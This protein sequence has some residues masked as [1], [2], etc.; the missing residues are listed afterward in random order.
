MA[1]ASKYRY[2]FNGKENDNEVKGIGD[3]IDYGMRV[4]DPRVG[5]FLSVD[6]LTKQYSW[7]TPYQYA[8]NK[9]VWKRDID[10]LE[11]ED[12][13]GKTGEREE[14]EKDRERDEHLNFLRRA[15]RTPTPEED[16]ARRR[17]LEDWLKK[18][19]EERGRANEEALRS[20]RLLRGINQY[21]RNS[22]N[23]AQSIYGSKDVNAAV[24]NYIFRRYSAK[25]TPQ[26]KNSVAS[27]EEGNVD[28]ALARATP[29]T[30]TGNGKPIVGNW[31]KGTAGNAG[32]VP[33][34]V[35]K[36]LRGQNFKSFDDFRAAFWKAVG[37]TPELLKGFRPTDI[38]LMKQG[39]APFTDPSQAAG[40]NRVQMVYQLHH[41]KPIQQGGAV[42]DVDNIMVVTPK[43]HAE[44]LSPNYHY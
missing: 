31:L 26:L 7:Y 39:F 3:Q 34:S 20:G 41:I 32:F 42:Y 11:E 38:S 5:R 23:A 18:S 10:G 43:Y 30:V 25:S 35:A 27:E 13:E 37:N 36:Q 1:G 2:G 14:L 19:P 15:L 9:P 6:P 29:G 12:E 8:G 16:A 17:E 28:A 4:Y 44:V 40:N 21:V 22:F 24:D 33:E